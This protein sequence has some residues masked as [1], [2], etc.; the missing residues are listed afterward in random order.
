LS[1]GAITGAPFTYVATV[2]VS[3]QEEVPLQ[4]AVVASFPNV[5]AIHVGDVLRYVTTHNL[6]EFTV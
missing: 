4:Q 3:P 2:R 1:P 6:I 5:S